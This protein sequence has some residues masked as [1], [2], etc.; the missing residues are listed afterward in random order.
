[1]YAIRSYYAFGKVLVDRAV[2]GILG[3]AA[4][5]VVLHGREELLALIDNPSAADAL[6]AC[7]AKPDT[8]RKDLSNFIDEHT[9]TS[10]TRLMR[11]SADSSCVV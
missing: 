10:T 6:R 11:V 8:L 3:P 5:D 2:V 9:P 7:G 1:M 4:M